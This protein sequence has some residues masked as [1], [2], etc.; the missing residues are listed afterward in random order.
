MKWQKNKK[1]F[2]FFSLDES[3]KQCFID[4]SIAG[5]QAANTSFKANFS[6][7]L[8]HAKTFKGLNLQ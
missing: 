1:N 8:L 3:K 6:F 2:F 5:R 4:Y 7:Q